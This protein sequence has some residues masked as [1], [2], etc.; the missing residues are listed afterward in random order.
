MRG[1]TWTGLSRNRGTVGNK[2]ATFAVARKI[3]I[4]MEEGE[5]KF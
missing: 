5:G 2:I 4:K 1:N 3:K